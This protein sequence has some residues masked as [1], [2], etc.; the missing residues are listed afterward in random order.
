MYD[1]FLINGK[2]DDDDNNHDRNNIVIP[3]CAV[4]LLDF[5]GQAKDTHKDSWF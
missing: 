1:L 2:K 5:L 3:W 4:K